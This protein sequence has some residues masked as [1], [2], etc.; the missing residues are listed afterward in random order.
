[1]LRHCVKDF[2]QRERCKQILTSGDTKLK[3]TRTISQTVGDVF[4]VDDISYV[5]SRVAL[6]LLNSSDIDGFPTP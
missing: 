4:S 3:S 6:S 5:T 2:M 1:M